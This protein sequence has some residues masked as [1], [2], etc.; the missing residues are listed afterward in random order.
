MKNRQAA[1]GK[2]Q[3]YF[4]FLSLYFNF[5]TH[6]YFFSLISGTC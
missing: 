4:L 1:E 5:L 3:T 6:F 2:V